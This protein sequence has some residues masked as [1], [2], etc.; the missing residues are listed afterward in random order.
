MPHEKRRPGGEPEAAIQGRE[1][2]KHSLADGGDDLPLDELRT[3]V[4]RVDP[5]LRKA[6]RDLCPAPRQVED[7]R[8]TAAE[9]RIELRRRE[10]EQALAG[11]GVAV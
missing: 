7:L 5:V 10:A 1:D 2:D 3:L 6:L 8:T 11:L 4:R 9:R